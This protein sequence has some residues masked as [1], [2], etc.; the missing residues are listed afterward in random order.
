M[1][2]AIMP[3][4]TGVALSAASP[5]NRVVVSPPAEGAAKQGPFYVIF[6][7][8]VVAVEPKQLLDQLK[9]GGRLAALKRTEGV[10]RGVVYA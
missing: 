6:I 8:G 4:L 1:R 10:V 2:M 5:A 3:W 9:D 7:G